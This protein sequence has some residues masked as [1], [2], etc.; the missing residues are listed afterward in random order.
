M[1]DEKL[2]IFVK[3]PRLGQV[4]SRLAKDIGEIAALHAYRT[5]SLEVVNSLQSLKS[6]DIC[7][8]PPDAQEELEHFIKVSGWGFIPQTDGDLGDR[9]SAAF[10]SAFAEGFS[11]V[12]IIGSDCP[13]V[14]PSDIT[15]AF[16]NLKAFPLVLGPASD[17]GYWLIGLNTMAEG[18]F[19][20]MPWSTDQL[21][22][23]TLK[24]ASN[25]NLPF[26]QLRELSDIDTLS[27][28]REFSART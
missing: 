21:L 12:V 27:D 5:L 10:R 15:E 4:K 20:S 6:V 16:D 19:Q 9:L 17:G 25:L 7:F 24:A 1:S 2:L 14:L 13:Y 22:Q 26:Q 28:W 11:R 18:L 8:T 3:A 23:H